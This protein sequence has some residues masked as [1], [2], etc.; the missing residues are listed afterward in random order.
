MV[1]SRTLEM[2]PALTWWLLVVYAFAGWIAGNLRQVV[3]SMNGEDD[4][5]VTLAAAVSGIVAA[6]AVGVSAGLW[7]LI[8]ARIEA[9]PVGALYAY[10]AAGLGAFGGV[11][12]LDLG[13]DVV[14]SIALKW[15]QRGNGG[16]KP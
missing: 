13:V 7:V 15:A 6:F 4:R 3:V 8:E 5:C 12:F 9:K 16:D 2:L 1:S 11:K 10:F 14:R